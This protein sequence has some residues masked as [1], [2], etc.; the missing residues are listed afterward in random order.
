MANS[1][2]ALYSL[3]CDDLNDAGPLTGSRA[4]AASLLRNSFLKKRRDLTSLSADAAAIDVWHASNQK[5][6]N[7]RLA[8][9]NSCVE[10]QIDASVKHYLDRFAITFPTSVDK[11]SYGPGASA[12]VKGT[13]FYVKTVGDVSM[14]SACI[15]RRY[16][17]LIAQ[18]RVMVA[19]ERD[20]LAQA[21]YKVV[22]GSKL[23]CVPKNDKISRSICVEPTLNMFLQKGIAYEL[24]SALLNHYNIDLA[25]QQFRNRRLARKGSIDRSFSTIDL[26]SASDSISVSWAREFLPPVLFESLMACRSPICQING[27]DFEQH[28]IGSQGNA[29]TFPLQTIIFATVVKAVYDVKGVKLVL[30][31]KG[32]DGNFGVYGDDI[33]CVQETYEAICSTLVRYG[34]T[35]NDDKSFTGWTQFR[36]SCGGDYYDGLNVRPVYLNSIETPQDRSSLYNRL[37]VWCCR[38]AVVLPKTL[39]QLSL[40]L[41]HVPLW[42]PENSGIRAPAPPGK[43][44][45]GTTLYKYSSFCDLS[46]TGDPQVDPDKFRHRFGAFR[47][48][49]GL[50]LSFLQGS[51]RDGRLEPIYR[52]SRCTLRHMYTSVWYAC[53]RSSPFL[54]DVTDEGYVCFITE[55]TPLPE[56]TA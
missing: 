30:N 35:V 52:S 55:H 26:K 31:K 3:L 38:H 13:S 53:D 9:P 49:S 16:A 1:P 4:F 10:E 47:S 23:C 51:L 45:S 12:Y 32:V 33:I 15:Y 50:F 39:K 43:F 14:T 56:A 44:R 41:P 11:Y 7:Y 40:G 25:D 5:C 20:R 22:S 42:S 19:C 18:H 34:F 46:R 27:V 21:E 37:M 29:N 48:E 2:D 6:A 17:A 8:M 36:E 24:E 28:M 54:E